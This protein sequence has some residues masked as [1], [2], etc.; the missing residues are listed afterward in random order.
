MRLDGLPQ[1]C[2]FSITGRFPNIQTNIQGY[3]NGPGFQV[4]LTNV[5][6]NRIAGTF[7]GTM[8]RVQGDGPATLQ[9]TNGKFTATF[10][11]N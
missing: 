10:D 5:S 1:G 7:S 2:S 3:S 4:T 8:N 11:N 6:G 9:V